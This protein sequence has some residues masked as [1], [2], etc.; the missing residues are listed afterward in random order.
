MTLKG[1]ATLTLGHANYSFCK[2]TML[3]SSQIIIAQG[4]RV[5]MFFHSPETCGITDNPATQL[6][7]TGGARIRTTST[8]PGDLKILFVGDPTG[9]IATAVNLTGNSRVTN[10][11][12]LY[13]PRS[14][15]TVTGN[16]TYVG[17]IAGKTLTAG[18]SATVLT[19]DRAAQAQLPIS[20]VFQRDR[21]VECSGGAMPG[22]TSTPD[23]R[24]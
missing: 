8:N 24:C 15:V 6:S 23:S 17:A 1:N 7:T 3:G 9:A 13:A 18:G 10:E 14:D 5:N 11:F 16:S 21:F 22:P 19:D 2:L 20:I 12:T 4:A